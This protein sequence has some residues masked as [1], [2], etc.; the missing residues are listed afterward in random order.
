MLFNIFLHFRRSFA[1]SSHSGTCNSLNSGFTRRTSL[2]S[3]AASSATSAESSANSPPSSHRPSSTPL[4][5]LLL[6]AYCVDAGVTRRRVR[7]LEVVAVLGEGILAGAL[8][9]AL[10]LPS[11]HGC[12]IF[13]KKKL[14][15]DFLRSEAG[16]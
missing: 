14:L 6:V 12:G 7:P 5:L 13:N 9:L 8:S 4:L 11:M 1:S 15:G 2:R 3:T 10:W 16:G